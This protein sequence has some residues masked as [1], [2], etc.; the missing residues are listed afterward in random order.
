MCISV[1]VV[2]I[3]IDN[4]LC[5]CMVIDLA[6]YLFCWCWIED[7]VFYFLL[8]SVKSILKAECKS[9]PYCTVKIKIVFTVK[10]GRRTI[11]IWDCTGRVMDPS[12]AW[13]CP[14]VLACRTSGGMLFH[15]MMVYLYLLC[16]VFIKKQNSFYIHLEYISAVLKR[17]FTGHVR[18]QR[19][20]IRCLSGAFQNAYA[21]LVCWI[22]QKSR[23]IYYTFVHDVDPW[24]DP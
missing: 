11:Y 16:V 7:A 10:T 12:H 14:M 9:C 24:H 19:E 20:C 3:S 1:A 23:L 13:N 21:C 22:L 6:W 5:M 18:G 17:S 15:V 8:L 4:I 2:M